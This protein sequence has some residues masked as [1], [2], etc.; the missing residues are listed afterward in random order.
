VVI[1]A[2][3][4]VGHQRWGT[5]WQSH[6]TIV[7]RIK[8]SAT[9]GAGSDYRSQ[10]S[11]GTA[12]VR[13]RLRVSRRPVCQ[14][15]HAGCGAAA[16]ADAAG[17]GVVHAEVSEEVL[18][19]RWL[20]NP[21]YQFFCGELSFCHRLPFERSSLTHCRQRLGEEQLTA[22][23]QESLSVAHK[24]GALATRDL[25]R[26]VVDTAVQPGPAPAKP[27]RDRPPDRCTAVPSGAGEAGRSGA[28]QR[29]AA[30]A[31]LSAGGK[32]RTPYELVCK[33]SIA[34]PVTKP[35]GGQFVLHAKVIHGNPSDGHTLGSVITELE[36][37]TGV[38]TRRI[39]VDKG[40]RGHNHQEKFPG[41]D[42]RT[43]ASRHRAD[44]PRDEA[45]RCC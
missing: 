8:G 36:T 38:E 26:V 1:C 10:P 15:L 43:G 40:Y 33:V 37:L 45:A 12:G 29:C 32:T 21:Y 41:L 27:G 11:A 13:D 44:P 39:H 16:V 4:G 24:T 42:H 14:R 3:P 17:R 19:A 31:E 22:L 6:G 23:I 28:A 30:A 34:T 5:R 35:T 18:C 2:I 9:A 25:E 20:E 7:K